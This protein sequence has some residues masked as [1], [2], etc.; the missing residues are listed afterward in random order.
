[1][2]PCD[3]RGRGEAHRADTPRF[4]L[5][6]RDVRHCGPPA[7]HVVRSPRRIRS[8]PGSPG[9]PR[10]DDLPRTAGALGFPFGAF[11]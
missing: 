10:P 5:G 9:G 6:A 8:N 3:R 4:V 1:M 11:R 2:P 7:G